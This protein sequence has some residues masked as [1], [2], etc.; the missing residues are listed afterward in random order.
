MLQ[1]PQGRHAVPYMPLDAATAART[2]IA[3][4]AS[5]RL[6]ELGLVDVPEAARASQESLCYGTAES[7]EVMSP[8]SSFQR[9]VA[10]F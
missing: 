10:A 2:T 4:V 8:S 9:L 3:L 6:A 7:H 5:R 1:P